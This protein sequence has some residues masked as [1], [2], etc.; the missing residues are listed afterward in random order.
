[1]LARSPE[2][3][4]LAVVMASLALSDVTIVA[5]SFASGEIVRYLT[6]HGR[7]RIAG[8]IMLGAAAIPYLLKTPDNPG[9]IPAAM[10]QASRAQLTA[11]FS[12]WAERNAAPYFAGQGSRCIIDATLAMMNAA[13]YQAMPALAEIQGVTDFRTELAVIDVPML[14][15]HGDRDA[16]IPLEMTSRPASDLVKGAGLLIYEGAPHGLY[17]THKDRLNRDI[18]EFARRL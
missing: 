6:R 12:G 16:S 8:V 5:H 18:A 14:F 9:G 13:S 3:D 7:D 11:D 10:M 2:G 1:M 4:D 15:I 17:V